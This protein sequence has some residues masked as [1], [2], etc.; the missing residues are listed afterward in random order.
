MILREIFLFFWITWLISGYGV[1]KVF[2][3][4]V[5]GSIFCEYVLV[6]NVLKVLFVVFCL[7][8]D[9]ILRGEEFKLLVLY[10]FVVLYKFIFEDIIE[11][12]I[13][14]LVIVGCCFLVL[15][16]GVVGFFLRNM[17]VNVLGFEEKRYIF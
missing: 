6:N 16:L 12:R 4:V 11:D 2:A 15:G 10:L 3:V 5:V 8:V 17:E 14:F 7:V 9:F 1:G 13:E